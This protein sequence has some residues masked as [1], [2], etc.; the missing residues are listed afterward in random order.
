MPPI[1]LVSRVPGFLAG[2]FDV[3]ITEQPEQLKLEITP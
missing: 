2:L 3:L 1:L